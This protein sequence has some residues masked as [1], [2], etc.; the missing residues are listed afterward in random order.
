[1]GSFSKD[2][3]HINELPQHRV[4]ITRPFQLAQVPVT[5]ELYEAVM[6]RNPSPKHAPGTPVVRVSWF[7]AIHFCNALSDLEGLEPA[8]RISQGPRPEVAILIDSKGYRL[9]TEAEWEYCARS[10]QAYVFS[11]SDEIHR[12]GWTQTD[13][14]HTAARKDPNGWGF[15]DLS[16]NIWEWCSDGL[17]EYSSKPQIDPIGE[18]HEYMHTPSARVIR[19]GSWCFEEDG[20]RVAFRGRGAPGLRIT[21]LGFRIARTI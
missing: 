5:Q 4:V 21:S 2:E 17:R 15:F 13:R 9:P 11:G 18:A 14:I 7:D 19:G 20:A 12:V 16:G 3:G 8:Y 10:Q 1:M 6:F